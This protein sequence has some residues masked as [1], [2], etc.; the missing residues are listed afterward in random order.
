MRQ[1][2]VVQNSIRIGVHFSTSNREVGF[3]DD[4]RISLSEPGS[5]GEM[6]LFKAD[7]VS[8]LV[9]SDQAE[10]FAHA[11]LS[12]AEESRRTPRTN[13]TLESDIVLL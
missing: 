11:L 8:F 7:E 2:E 10:H 6:S 3:D 5:K 4:I 9:T 12:A 13:F 1:I